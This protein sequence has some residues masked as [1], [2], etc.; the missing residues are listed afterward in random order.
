MNYGSLTAVEERHATLLMTVCELN[1][2]MC[3]CL[4]ANIL[5][6]EAKH[7]F[8]Y[9]DKLHN[10]YIYKMPIVDM[11]VGREGMRVTSFSTA[12]RYSV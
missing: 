8:Q 12:L 4:K 7:V 3:I 11:M 9:K 6:P 2:S 10:L 1:I 5:E